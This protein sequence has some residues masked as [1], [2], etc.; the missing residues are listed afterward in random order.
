MYNLS[1]W[2][3]FILIFELIFCSVTFSSCYKHHVISLLGPLKITCRTA[4]YSAFWLADSTRGGGAYELGFHLDLQNNLSFKSNVLQ[5]R[6]RGESPRATCLLLLGTLSLKCDSHM[7]NCLLFSQADEARG[8]QK[9][10]CEFMSTS[11]ACKIHWYNVNALENKSAEHSVIYT[12]LTGLYKSVFRRVSGR[13]YWIINIK[14]C[15]LTGQSWC[16]CWRACIDPSSSNLFAYASTNLAYLYSLHNRL[17][18]AHHW[19][20]LGMQ[21]S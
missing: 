5:L 12:Q 20:L 18:E 4:A 9:V 16:G 21:N 1:V 13:S 6:L 11:K 8:A 17:V 7:C 15:V 3:G 10:P 14:S 2:N 19:R